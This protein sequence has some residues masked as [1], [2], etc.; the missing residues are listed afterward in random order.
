MTLA[1]IKAK[2]NDLDTKLTVMFF[3]HKLATIKHFKD[4]GIADEKEFR[5]LGDVGLLNLVK[6][7]LI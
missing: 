2:L 1:P 4:K 3:S 6:G 5:P 7:G